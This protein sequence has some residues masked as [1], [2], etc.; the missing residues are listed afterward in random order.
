MFNRPPK[1]RSATPQYHPCNVPPFVRCYM[2]RGATIFHDAMV[3]RARSLSTPA[4]TLM[5]KERP[6]S[7]G[8]LKIKN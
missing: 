4:W 1:T 8:W 2:V 5:G 3:Q 7:Y 6:R